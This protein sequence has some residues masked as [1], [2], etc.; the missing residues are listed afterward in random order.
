[1]WFQRLRLVSTLLLGGAAVAAGC[2]ATL[3]FDALS[4][5]EATNVGDSG[6]PAT[7]SGGSGTT[8]GG[9]AAGD[10][11]TSTYCRSLNPTPTFCD[12]FDDTNPLPANRWSAT[13]QMGGAITVDSLASV[14][15]SMSL[16]AKTSTALAGSL[17]HAIRRKEFA[18][19]ADT[20]AGFRID[21]DMRIEDIDPANQAQITVF[22]MLFGLENDYYQLVMNVDVTGGVFS[23]K[24]AENAYAADA[25][26]Y[27]AHGFAGPAPLQNKWLHAHIEIDVRSPSGTDGNALRVSIDGKSQFDGSLS[28]PLKGK[29]PRVEMGI[30]YV[31][32]PS[33]PWTIRYDNIVADVKSID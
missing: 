15:P 9:G 28:V 1:M 19:F 4:N 5:G 21:F 11:A 7:D 12:D 17:A 13:D 24:M 6:K 29:A 23:L 26:G 27:Q 14:S 25:S 18:A 16:L 30:G 22:A 10:S 32:A 3:D 8:G 33:A 20:K 2:S 31:K